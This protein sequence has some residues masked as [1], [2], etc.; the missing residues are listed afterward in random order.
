[1]KKIKVGIIGLGYWGPNLVRNFSNH[2]GFSVTRGADLIDANLE[3]IKKELPLIS[4][5]KN[6][7]EL[8]NDPDIDLIVIATPPETHHQLALKALNHGKNIW[9]EKPFTTKYED[10]K[11]VVDLAKSLNLYVHIDFPFIFSGPVKKIKSI[12]DKKII[13][14]PYYFDSIRTNL[15]NIQSKVD[16]IWDLAPHD[17]SIIFYLFPEF[18]FKNLHYNGSSH[19]KHNNLSQIA[20]LVLDF[21]DDFTAY[22]HLSWLSPVKTRLITI[23]GSKQMVVFD[24]V[25]PSEKIKV[26]DKN[27]EIEKTEVTPFKPV[28]R[29]GD[30]WVPALDQTEALF[31][32]VSYVYEQLQQK[33]K[34]TMTSD[35]ALK[36]LTILT[37]AHAE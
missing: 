1:M 23:G 34:G 26:Y 24:D 28:Y 21:S 18:S 31:S 32:A 19:I 37:L 7:D 25:Q 5:T 12:L 15:G 30:I 13:G 8:F 17:L 35:I 4:L 9:V 10:A 33:T 22:I 36:V 11:E 14:K 20:N 3:K 6:S 29:T 27:I 2:D 16:V